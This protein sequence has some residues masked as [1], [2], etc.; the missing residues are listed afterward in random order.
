MNNALVNIWTF[1]Q[2]HTSTYS[3]CRYYISGSVYMIL[4]LNSVL[5]KIT[6]TYARMANLIQCWHM[7]WLARLCTYI[8]VRSY[9]YRSCLYLFMN[10]FLLWGLEWGL[11]SGIRVRSQ[12]FVWLRECQ[13][14][15][16]IKNEYYLACVFNLD[17]T[18]QYIL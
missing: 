16:K 11:L 5:Y 12:R 8:C 13:R 10:I 2:T 6:L 18:L 7:L 17:I 1:T 4:G 14:F 3:L 15:R 9:M